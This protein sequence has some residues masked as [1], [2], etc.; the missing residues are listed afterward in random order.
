MIAFDSYHYAIQAE[1]LLARRMPVR[2]MPTLRCVS[3]S[4]GMSLRLAVPDGEA[5]PAVLRFGGLP[6]A[7]WRRYLVFDGGREARL[8]TDGEAAKHGLVHG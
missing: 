8:C 2:V 6:D 3:E 4:C 5:A 1:Q 7:V